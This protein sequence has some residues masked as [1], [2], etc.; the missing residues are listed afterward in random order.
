M[1]KTILSNYFEIKKNSIDHQ[2]Q[3]FLSKYKQEKI[4]NELHLTDQEILDNSI[5]IKKAIDSYYN[6]KDGSQQCGNGGFHYILVKNDNKLELKM[7]ECPFQNEQNHLKKILNNYALKE[8]TSIDYSLTTEMYPKFKNDLNEIKG[9]IVNNKK[10]LYI[11]NEHN[12]FSEILSSLTNELA[13]ENNTIIFLNMIDL[14]TYVINLTYNNE[15]LFNFIDQLKN[16]DFLILDEVGNEK[17]KQFIHTNILYTILHYRSIK[18][19]PI[20]FLSQ[21]NL[22]DLKK[23]Y[24]LSTSFKEKNKVEHYVN[25]ILNMVNK[26]IYK[27]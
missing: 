1:K 2:Q 13:N 23:Q 15:N 24:E 4:I 17:F 19:K 14:Y 12:N 8:I 3:K 7:I 18:K 21:F 6:C 20:I 9:L 25:K 10:N 16:V 26:K 11:I 27:Y 5:K 22:K